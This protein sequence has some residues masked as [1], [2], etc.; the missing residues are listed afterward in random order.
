M[1]DVVFLKLVRGYDFLS[2]HQ[3][4]PRIKG[5]REKFVVV[6]ESRKE[7]EFPSP[8]PHVFQIV[9]LVC[10]FSTLTE[11]FAALFP[12]IYEGAF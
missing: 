2:S 6:W 5:V 11:L 10:E 1:Y 4:P 9:A 12:P 3:K 8:F 7:E